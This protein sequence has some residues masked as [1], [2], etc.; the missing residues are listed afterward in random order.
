MPACPACGTENDSSRTNCLRCG[1]LLAQQPF[2]FSPSAAGVRVVPSANRTLLGFAS[3]LA[4][5]A[6]PPQAAAPQPGAPA[7]PL[8]AAPSPAA[9]PAYAPGTGPKQTLMGVALPGIAPLNPGQ[10]APA[11]SAQLPRGLATTA[12]PPP[13][14]NVALTPYPSLSARDGDPVAGELPASLLRAQS[15]AAVAL[16]E[17]AAGS[18]M[19]PPGSRMP[20]PGSR[21]PPPNTV[22]ARRSL[23]AILG[24][25]AAALVLVAG[26]GV[27]L[28][29]TT[30]TLSVEVVTDEAQRDQ[31]D[32]SC[33][34]C[35]DGTKV[36]SAGQLAIVKSGRARLALAQPLLLGN[37]E[38]SLRVERPD[39][40]RPSEVRASFPLEYRLHSEL[41]GLQRA[42]PEIVVNVEALPGALVTIDG[43]PVTLNAEGKAEVRLDVTSSLA[44]TASQVLPLEKKISYAVTLPRTPREVMRGVLAVRIGI[45][46]LELVT[47]H[48]SWSTDQAQVLV[49]GRTQKGARLTL[50]ERPVTVAPDGQFSIAVALP[51][52]T[53]RPRLRASLDGQAP[54]IVQLSLENAAPRHKRVLELCAGLRSGFELAQAAVQSRSPERFWFTGELLESRL[55]GS[56][57][58]A[59][60]SVPCTAGSCVVR[61][62]LPEP[63]TAARGSRFRWVGR[64]LELDKAGRTLD[65]AAESLAREP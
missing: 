5:G 55:E 25:T 44:G 54:R 14:A 39:E 56:V 1:T 50:D 31:L 48:D 15:M 60:F 40:L 63:I 47:P 65:V 12:P 11:P 61:L 29:R 4:P 19:P 41:S 23:A 42:T 32:V 9:H 16:P 7:S 36:L 30:P 51:P 37:N 46:P 21:M 43:R 27:L 24:G 22:A 33:S 3:P 38:V 52:G 35:P 45:T 64:A 53:L 59:L 2:G 34:N 18:R 26:T 62:Q 8:P 57:T 6:D 49:S 28:W 17:P 58:R 20:P 10:A 13:P